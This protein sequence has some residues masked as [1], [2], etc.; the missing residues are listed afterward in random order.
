MRN[1]S[2]DAAKLVLGDRNASYGSPIDDYRKTAK[3]WSGM[4]ANMLKPGCE[5]TAKQAAIM[6]VAL[7]LSREMH[8]HKPDNMI[9]A[10]GYLNVAQWIEDNEMPSMVAEQ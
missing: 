3:I 2:A 5:I 6:M 1:Y 7:K 10:I 8:K 4:L 9:D